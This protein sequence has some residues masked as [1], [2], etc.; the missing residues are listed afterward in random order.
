MDLFFKNVENDKKYAVI[1]IVLAEIATV[2]KTAFIYRLSNE[3]YK[4]YMEND[5]YLCP[6][7]GYD[8]FSLALKYKDINIKFIIWDTEWINW[9]RF[10][11][12]LNLFKKADIVF[13]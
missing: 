1:N 3:N 8:F 12:N 10:Y 13:L 11:N 9:L 6:I 2:G 5:K 4:D 7:I